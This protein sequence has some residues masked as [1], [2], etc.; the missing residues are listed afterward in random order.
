LLRRTIAILGGGPGGYEAALVAAQL[1]ADV[2]VVDS[3][4]VGGA[5]VLTDCVPSKTLIET[6]NAMTMLNRAPG[7]G[8]ATGGLATVNAA[9]LY[10]RITD[11]ARAQSQDI[12]ARLAAEQVKVIAGPGRLSGPG[13]IQAGGDVTLNAD[14]DI[15]RTS[16]VATHVDISG[17]SISLTSQYGTV[18]TGLEEIIVQTD[19]AGRGVLSGSSYENIFVQQLDSELLLGTITTG[20]GSVPGEAF[21]SNPGGSI[22]NGL[23]NGVNIVSGTTYLFANGNIGTSTDKI[24]SETPS[25][26][27]TAEVEGQASGSGSIW[28]APRFCAAVKKP[29]LVRIL[30]LAGRRA[31][32]RRGGLWRR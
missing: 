27:P 23:F 16:T 28:L 1:G 25:N 17:N 15:Q 3:D 18:G 13:T 9:R 11:L 21:I 2:T 12:T 7:L 4:G 8:I 19:A 5:C 22:Y 10:E 31:G 29:V 24:T 14:V 20:T 30:Q 6:S 26:A 32:A